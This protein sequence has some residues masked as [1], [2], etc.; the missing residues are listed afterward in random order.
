LSDLLDVQPSRVPPHLID[1][2]LFYLNSTKQKFYDFINKPYSICE[3]FPDKLLENVRLKGKMLS[4]IK[5]DGQYFPLYLEKFKNTK[6]LA[7]KVNHKFFNLRFFNLDDKFK[8]NID[9]KI[10]KFVADPF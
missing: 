7:A 5:N 4:R 10:Q 3:G 6:V 8:K 2:R 1:P 9:L